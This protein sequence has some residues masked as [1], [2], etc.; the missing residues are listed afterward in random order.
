MAGFKNFSTMGLLGICTGLLLLGSCTRPQSDISKIQIVV[1]KTLLSNKFG[2]LVS[3]EQLSHVVINITGEGISQPIVFNWDLCADCATVNTPPA[4]FVLEVPMGNSRLVQVLAVYE[5][6][7]TSA[8]SFYYGDK[9]ENFSGPEVPV[10][11]PVASMGSG[12]VIG[13]SIMGRYLTSVNSGIASGPTGEV[14]IRYRAAA[15][16]PALIIE[17]NAIINGW[18]NFFGLSGTGLQ[19]EYVLTSTGELLFGGPV[20]LDSSIFDPLV[21]PN[22]LKIAL[23]VHKRQNSGGGTFKPAEAEKLIFGYWAAAGSGVNPSSY[24]VCR[25]LAGAPAGRFTYDIQ[26]PF[27]ISEASGSFPTNE[28]LANTSSPLIYVSFKGGKNIDGSNC[29]GSPMVA[30][31]LFESFFKVTSA[32][33]NNG[34]ETI[35]GFNVPFRILGSNNQTFTVTETNSQKVITGRTLPGVS[36]V[37]DSIVLFKRVSPAG[38]GTYRLENVSCEKLP[39]GYSSAGSAPIDAQGNF[40]INSNITSAEAING[41]SAIACGSKAG[42]LFSAGFFIEKWNFSAGGPPLVPATDWNLG[43]HAFQVFNGSC[44]PAWIDLIAAG[45]NYNVTNAT[46]RVFNVTIS[47]VT[48]TIYSNEAC[49]TVASSITVPAGSTHVKFYYQVSG[50][51]TATVT[52]NSSGFGKGSMNFVKLYGGAQAGISSFAGLM[53]EASRVNTSECRDVE[54]YFLDANNRISNLGY[55]SSPMAWT[56]NLSLANFYGGVASGGFRIVDNCTAKNPMTSLPIASGAYKTKFAIDN[57]GSSSDVKLVMSSPA[58]LPG[59]SAITSAIYLNPSPVV[60]HLELAY[61]SNP[62]F[63]GTCYQ[64]TVASKDSSNGTMTVPS[65]KRVRYNIQAQQSGTKFYS[66]LS[67]CQSNAA[68]TLGYQGWIDQSASSS[69]FYVKFALGGI[70]T[71][72]SLGGSFSLVNS[73]ANIPAGPINSSLGPSAIISGNPSLDYGMV[74]IGNTAD[75]TLTLQNQTGETLTSLNPFSIAAPFSFKGGAFPG[76][77]GTCGATLAAGVSCTA[78][79]EFAPTSA[80]PFNHN[81]IIGFT[82]GAT[83]VESVGVN[84]TG[85]GN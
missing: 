57:I 40:T 78:I 61:S 51:S 80:G 7:V 31:D 84:V 2:A 54:V 29:D 65:G 44:L 70:N 5:D 69:V 25:D 17:N 64:A 18:F 46:N 16:K 43:T 85:T 4:A 75:I 23:P 37:F 62:T 77:G 34:R 67:S 55:S 39:E 9:T 83:Q 45:D 27:S 82:N 42:S 33:F 15:N 13:G 60:D 12:A 8:M 6:N 76:T 74:T 53:G 68:G 28:I 48:G 50:G 11:V 19:M 14:Q 3:N 41:V 52:A 35:A 32:G 73:A 22:I 58:S 72:I 1:P 49:S 79:L 21:D 56:M 24:K 30:N 36:A 47:G 26:N 59:S 71:S 66:D 38:E 81:V 63:A 10:V 20:S